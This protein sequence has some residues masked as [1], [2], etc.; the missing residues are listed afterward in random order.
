[1]EVVDV[2]EELVMAMLVRLLQNE[3]LNEH[4]LELAPIDDLLGEE[5]W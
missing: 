2:V 5:T 3:C 1:M 4:E